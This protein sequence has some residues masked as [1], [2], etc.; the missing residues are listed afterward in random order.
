MYNWIGSLKSA[1]IIRQKILEDQDTVNISEFEKFL[2]VYIY[3]D[4]RGKNHVEYIE[5]NFKNSK[6]RYILDNM[7]FKNMA[8]YYLRSKTPE[9][10]LRHT[11]LLAD[12][13]IKLKDIRKSGK[14]K[15]IQQLKDKK[16]SKD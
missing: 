16:M 9:S 1:P 11:K 3:S 14:G 8:Y 5:N 6:K 13:K 10:D 7:F 15:F 4:I 12:I 2:S